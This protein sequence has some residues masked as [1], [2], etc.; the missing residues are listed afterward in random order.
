MVH[1]AILTI[2]D[3]APSSL[4]G[5]VVRTG[6]DGAGG[7]GGAAGRR[8]RELAHVVEGGGRAARARAGARLVAP[9]AAAAVHGGAVL[10]VVLARGRGV[11]RLAADPVHVGE[12]G[13]VDRA[14]AGRHARLV[15]ELE[16]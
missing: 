13:A 9:G 4:A 3:E 14:P 1:L 10:L 11:V 12:R 15:G 16:D 6:V 7:A 2:G 8:G 5:V